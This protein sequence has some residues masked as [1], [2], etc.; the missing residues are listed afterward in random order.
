MRAAVASV[1]AIATWDVAP[2]VAAGQALATS[3]DGRAAAVA[4]RQGAA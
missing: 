3:R 1:L 4:A 2:L